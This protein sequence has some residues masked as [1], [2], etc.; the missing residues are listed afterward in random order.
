MSVHVV[1]DMVRTGR[2]TPAQGAMLLQLRREIA[3]AR[4]P[5]WVRA[6]RVLGRMV[7]G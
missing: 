7:F 2:I 4:Q 3:W 5:W 1:H 6:L